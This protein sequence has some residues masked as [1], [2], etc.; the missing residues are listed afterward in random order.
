MK[1]GMERNGMEPI[2]ACADFK[3]TKFLVFTTTQFIL[4]IVYNSY[5]PFY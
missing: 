4:F 5:S 2:G 3:I 1:P